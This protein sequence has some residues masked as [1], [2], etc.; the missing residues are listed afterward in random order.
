M[1]FDCNVPRIWVG[2]CPTTR[3]N[4]LLDALCWMNRVVSPALIEKL[5]QFRI[6]PGVF[7]IDSTP[8]WLLNVACPLTTCGPAGLASAV[9][10]PK[11]PASSAGRSLHLM[12][13]AL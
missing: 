8:P 9:P 13:R 5:C 1:P 10:Q 7:V 6:A 11:Q 2:S 4:T 3:F 12:L